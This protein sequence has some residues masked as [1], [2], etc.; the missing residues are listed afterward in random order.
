MMGWFEEQMV[1]H[2]TYDWQMADR[3]S[4]EPNTVIQHNIVLAGTAHLAFMPPQ[5]LKGRTDQ[6]V[7]SGLH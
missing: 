2:Y 7:L 4:A 6:E 3:N 5:L 1:V